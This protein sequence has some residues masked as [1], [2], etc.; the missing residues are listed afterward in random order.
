MKENEITPFE[1]IRRTDPDGGDDWSS[2]DLAKVLGYVNY[3]HLLAVIE[4]AKT[5]CENSDQA[6]SDQMV[7]IG[8]GAQRA[9][10]VVM[11]SRYACD[12][13]IQN[14]DPSQEIVAQGQTYFAIQTRRQ[15]LSDEELETKRRLAIRTELKQHNS[16]LA[17]A[18]KDARVIKPIDYAIFQNH[19]DMGLYDELSAQDIHQRKGLKK[20]H[21]S[22]ITWAALNSR[23]IDSEP[24]RRKKNYDAKRSL[25]KH[26]PTKR[27]VKSVPKSVKPSKISEAR[28]LKH[29][30]PPI[31]LKN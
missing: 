6:I 23:P 25:A 4:K 17:N 20:S 3:R 24:H 29:D 15:E 14:A 31:A 7:D 26:R 19:G 5:A 21:K 27:I 2:C 22:S 1:Q 11:M 28:C 10:K 9:L 30:L 13:V 8:S 18:T 12:L 16:Q